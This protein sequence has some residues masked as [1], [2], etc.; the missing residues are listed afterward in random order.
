M[1]KHFPEHLM[2]SEP[3]SFAR[4]TIVERKPQ[5]IRRMIA[6][7][8]YPPEIVRALDAFV[9]EIASQT[10]QGITEDT[11]H[12]ATWNQELDKYAGKTWLQVPWY[13]AETF[14][15]RRL[16]EIVR[17]FQPGPLY[18]Q[19]PFEKQK[20][21]Q[22]E[23]AVTQV[24]TVWDQL[25]AADPTVRFEALLHSCLWGNRVDLSNYTLTV[26]AH[27]GLDARE[28]RHN[29]LIDHTEKVIT[30]LSRGAHRVDFINDNAGIDLLSDVVLAD[31]LIQKGLSQRIVF[32]LKDRPFFVSDAMPKD[33]L[34]TIA[35]LRHAQHPALEALGSRLAG[36][37]ESE[38][39]V[40]DADP[41]WTSPDAFHQMPAALRSD[42]EKAD[43]V[44]LKGDVNY[45]RMLDDRHW[46]FDARLEE[47]GA[48][49]PKPFVM[50]RTLKGEIMVGLGPGQAEALSASDPTWLIN[51][52][53][54]VIHLV[55]G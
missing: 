23:S 30:L 50:M 7:N 14:F 40:L 21:E 45:R 49:F 2:T 54:G 32:H 11:T 27:G 33:L 10:I 1:A 47:L 16:L 39:F 52:K 43:L 48:Y 17:Y 38:R 29:I 28:H 20:Q 44:I 8:D 15:Y 18:L 5:I 26:K 4:K 31:Y 9:E 22:E 46:P 3:G 53:R 24:A 55:T 37:V 51:G 19:D 6:D 36:F 25:A 12:T 42:I 13:F 41:F 34:T 35:L